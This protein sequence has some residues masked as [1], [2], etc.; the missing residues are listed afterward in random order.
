LA[1]N[2]QTKAKDLLKR[3]EALKGKLVGVIMN[4]LPYFWDKEQDYIHA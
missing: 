3:I 1:N 4:C 2:V